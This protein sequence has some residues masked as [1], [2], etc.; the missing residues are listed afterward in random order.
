[1]GFRQIF[2]SRKGFHKNKSLKKN[3]LDYTRDVA[4]LMNDEVGRKFKEAVV[5]LS[6]LYPVI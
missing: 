4:F 3:G 5:D 6:R 1:M 2:E